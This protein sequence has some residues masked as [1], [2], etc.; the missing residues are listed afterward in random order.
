MLDEGQ[1]SLTDVLQQVEN[2]TLE[3][4]PAAASPQTRS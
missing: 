2:A 3:K 1:K 4:L